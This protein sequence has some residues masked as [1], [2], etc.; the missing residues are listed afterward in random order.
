MED[1]M[2]ADF[3]LTGVDERNGL[4]VCHPAWKGTKLGD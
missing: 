1:R 4:A 2:K 3:A